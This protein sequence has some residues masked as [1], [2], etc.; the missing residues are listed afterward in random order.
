MNSD[1]VATSKAD[2]LTNEHGYRA[3]AGKSCDSVLTWRQVQLGV[4]DTCHQ[5][6]HQQGDAGLS[7]PCCT[8]RRHSTTAAHPS[9]ATPGSSLLHSGL[10]GSW[11]R[12]AAGP[13]TPP[14]SHRPARMREILSV[15][16]RP[17]RMRAPENYRWIVQH[18][19]R[20]RRCASLVEVRLRLGVPRYETHP[21]VDTEFQNVNVANRF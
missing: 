12:D 11:P 21:R 20:R 13:G 10:F 15:G 14:G 4:C 6:K 19:C 9:P 16:R 3:S 7:Q 1:P 8:H 2:T 18:L 17:V 5:A